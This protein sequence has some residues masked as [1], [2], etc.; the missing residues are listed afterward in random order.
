MYGVLLLRSSGLKPPSSSFVPV[1]S[2]IEALQ[3]LAL[4]V[5]LRLPTILTSAPSAGKALI[6][7]HLASLVHPG[8]Q[9]QIVTI[10][11]ADTSLDPRSL[12]GSYVSS[13]VHPGTFEWKD[14]T[15]I[16]C[17]REGKWVVFKD[18]D[19]G[20]PEI[21]GI[22]KPL[23]ESLELGKWI[24]GLAKLDV[25]SHGTVVAHDFFRLFSTRSS[26]P[27]E[28]GTFSSST[29]FGSHRFAE[30]FL[31]TPSPSELNSI[32]SAKFPRLAGNAAR[33]IIQVWE[34][35][36]QM[37]PSAVGREVGLKEL[38]KFCRRIDALLL[39]HELSDVLMEDGMLTLVDVFPNPSVREEIFIEARD[40]FFG[41]GTPTPASRAL[42]EAVARLVGQHLGL[43]PERQ[44]WVLNG[45]LPYFEIE[46]DSGGR[47]TAVHAGRACILT[48]SNKSTSNSHAIRPFTM[49][50]PA[51]C[52]ISRIATSVSHSEPVLL[53]GETGTGKTSIITHLASLLHQPLIS[54]N[55]SHQTESS[56]LIGGLKPTDAR[57][58]AAMLQEKFVSIFGATFSRRKNEKFETEIRK[59]INDCKW[60]RAVGLWKESGRLAVERL[61]AK[62]AQS[63]K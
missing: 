17:M 12:L 40:I 41:F 36:K 4:H 62:E 34:E 18:I 60:K 33:V 35:I 25:P 46:K 1:P 7:S 30:V 21:L 11:L 58:P 53:T 61:Q 37:G 5:S 55:L 44:K 6:L 27:S 19:R 13:T 23:S 42:C 45:K 43:D 48:S 3:Q 47:T 29:F 15:L 50:K 49:H 56:D 20:S 54:L 31:R 28:D 16:R 10:Q 22:I 39:S 9:N 59:A 24:G 32:V 51:L 26:L 63:L 2:S 52:L 57:I 14:G 38:L 8:D